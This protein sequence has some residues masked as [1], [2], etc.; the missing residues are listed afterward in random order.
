M[1]LFRPWIPDNW[2]TYVIR[3]SLKPLRRAGRVTSA[4]VNPASFDFKITRVRLYHHNLRA[5]LNTPAGPLWRKLEARAV[6]AQKGAQAQVG[7]KTG[8][9]KASIY[10]RHLGNYTG[11]YITIGSDLSYALMHHEGT[12]P[13]V[14][15]A[16][17]GGKL[18]FTVNGKRVFTSMVRHPGTQ[19]N[20]YLTRQ[21]PIFKPRIVIT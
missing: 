3:K 6:L 1:P 9:L 21:L 4:T 7:V 16:S 14:I 13:H 20:R 12:R 19:P 2:G 11:Q 17:P 8:R 18:K 5:Y 15:T 10:K